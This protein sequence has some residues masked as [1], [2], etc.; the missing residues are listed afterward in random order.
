M[1][2]LIYILL[3]PVIVCSQNNNIIDVKK[4]NKIVFST[5]FGAQFYYGNKFL[6]SD[7]F[8]REGFILNFNLFLKKRKKKYIIKSNAIVS[9][10]N[11]MSK[12]INIYNPEINTNFTTRAPNILACNINYSLSIQSELKHNLYHAICLKFRVFPIFYKKGKVMNSYIYSFGGL[13]ASESNG[14]LP[15]LEKAMQ[16]SYQMLYKL[17]NTSNIYI[18]CFFNSDWT[19]K[20][21]QTGLLYPGVSFKFEK[22]INQNIKVPWLSRFRK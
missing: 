13:I 14:S 22:I 8:S 7:Q 11:A 21:P 9:L 18:T 10:S 17:T 15:D 3:F 1:K 16:L 4:S 12:K 19:F 5:D 20:K 2:N 6:D